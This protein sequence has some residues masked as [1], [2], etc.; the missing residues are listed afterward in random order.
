[1][2]SCPA[3]AVITSA[4]ISIVRPAGPTI[5]SSAARAA[6]R[7]ATLSSSVL[8]WYCWVKG[9]RGKE[10]KMRERERERERERKKEIRKSKRE[11]T[12]ERESETEEKEREKK[13]EREQERVC[14]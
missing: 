6:L 1:M 3:T 7:I 11:R 9:A 8:V 5:A 14:V 4:F 12:K 13:R 10:M 2:S